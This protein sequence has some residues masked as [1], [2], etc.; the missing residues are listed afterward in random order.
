MEV[1]KLGKRTTIRFT[2]QTWTHLNELKKFYPQLSSD[3]DVVNFLLR[4][5][6]E[7]LTKENFNPHSL[8]KKI[9]GID[10]N[11]LII[12]Q[13]I[14]G[15]MDLHGISNFIDMRKGKAYNEGLELAKKYL[16]EMQVKKHTYE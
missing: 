1:I 4:Q 9:A 13:M 12:L 7:N 6:K 8:E 14:S 5:S 16:Q 15:Y 10:K 3:S 2:E 11:I